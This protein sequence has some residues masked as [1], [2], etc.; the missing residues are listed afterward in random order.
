MNIII[1]GVG[2]VGETLI[3]NFI[4]E[5]HN[6]VVVDKN[7]SLVESIVNRHDV[8]GAV[9]SCLERDV[10]TNAGVE[11]A[12]FLLACT[13]QDE[14]NILTCVLDHRKEHDEV[15]EHILLVLI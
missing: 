5:N 9:G 3:K 4:E 12:D 7:A 13:S 11:N 1:V 10:L 15:S 14:V 8:M 2:K 6:V